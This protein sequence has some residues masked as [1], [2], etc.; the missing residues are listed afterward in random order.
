MSEI[1]SD[2][3]RDSFASVDSTA[4]L[5]KNE[6]EIDSGTQ[7]KAR[8]CTYTTVE[9]SYSGSKPPICLDSAVQYQEIDIR[10]TH[11]SFFNQPL[12]HS[13]PPPPP[14]LPMTEG[15]PVCIC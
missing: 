10:T 15:G 8:E 11:V 5:V 6:P 7:P 12:L 2:L 9:T 4:P 3:K 13:S 1:E 14:I